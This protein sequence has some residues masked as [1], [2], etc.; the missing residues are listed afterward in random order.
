MHATKRQNL[1]ALPGLWVVATPIGNLGDLTDRARAALREA[2][3]ILCED[4]RRT[5]QLIAA[6]GMERVKGSRLERFDAHTGEQRTARLVERMKAGEIFALASDAGTPAISDPGAALVAMARQAGVS[7]T[8]IPGASSVMALLSVAGFEETAFVFRGFFPRKS[9]ERERE[10]E[11]AAA[12]KLARVFV[13]FESPMR[14]SEALAEIAERFPELNMIVAKELTKLHE[15]HF[16]GNAADVAAQVK[17]EIQREGALGEWCFAAHFPPPPGT[18]EEQELKSSDWVKA[19]YCLINAR[20]SA[21][22]AARQVSQ[23]FGVG[24]KTVYELALEISGKK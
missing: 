24:K 10:L 20:V 22:E 7:V 17:D 15:R 9:R 16:S 21:S 8:P 3:V 4:T 11:L 2:D 14:V 23:Y 5:A 1:P 12:S 19:L 13:W 6:L 18:R